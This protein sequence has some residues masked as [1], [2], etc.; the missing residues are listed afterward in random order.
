[1][2]RVTKQK[3]QQQQHQEQQQQQQREAQNDFLKKLKKI[4]DLKSKSKLNQKIY[5]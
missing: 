4:L 3:Q 1:M 5:K 2:R